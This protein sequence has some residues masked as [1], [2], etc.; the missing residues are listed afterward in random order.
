MTPCSP[1]SRENLHVH[2]VQATGGRVR[3]LA[4]DEEFC[5]E[6]MWYRM[7]DVRMKVCWGDGISCCRA[8]EADQGDSGR[9]SSVLTHEPLCW[10]FGKS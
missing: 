2:A 1:L 5:G 8:Y 7:L 4:E 10:A 3:A 9:I 6:A